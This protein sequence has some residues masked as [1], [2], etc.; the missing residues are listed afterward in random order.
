[1][2]LEYP[3]TFYYKAKSIICAGEYRF[4]LSS[5]S[6]SQLKVEGIYIEAGTFAADRTLNVF[7]GREASPFVYILKDYALSPG[8]KKAI[9]SLVFGEIHV[10]TYHELYIK[11]A[12]MAKDEEVTITIVGKVSTLAY[13]SGFAINSTTTEQYNNIY[14]YEEQ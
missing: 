3:Y 13:P 12:A 7:L 6:L 10:F 11:L 14:G 1:M 8:E 2:T 4:S 9:S 5:R